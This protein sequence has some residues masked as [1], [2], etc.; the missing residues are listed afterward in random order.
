MTRKLVGQLF[1]TGA[2]AA[3]IGISPLVATAQVNVPCTNFGDGSNGANGAAPT[4]CSTSTTHSASANAFNVGNTNR[5][6]GRVQGNGFV[7]NGGQS[8][9]AA[10]AAQTDSQN[11]SF[12]TTKG[13]GHATVSHPVVVGGRT[14]AANGVGGGSFVSLGV[15]GASN[16]GGGPLAP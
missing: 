11:G 9:T 6:V 12:N 1:M 10:A 8:N 15:G 14:F 4:V 2:V 5:P 16:T 13:A 3:A 7:I